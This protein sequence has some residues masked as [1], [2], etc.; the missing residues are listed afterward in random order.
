M[1]TRRITA[2]GGTVLALLLIAGCRQYE[3]DVSV[4]PDGSGTRTLRLQTDPEDLTE[5]ESDLEGF[6]GLYG[7]GPDSGWT[8]TREREEGS[9]QEILVFSRKSQPGGLEDWPHQSGDL[10]IRGTLEPGEFAGVAFTNEL[11]VE[12]VAGTNLRTYTYR[13]RFTW[14]GLREILTSRQAEGFY[15]R[16]HASYPYLTDEDRLEL[17]GLLAGAILATV[18]LE[19]S[20][21][22]REGVAE[23]LARAVEA[24]AE[25]ILH[26][27]DPGAACENLAQI[28][29][30]AIEGADQDLEAFLRHELPG[31]Y[32]A[33]ATSISLRVTMPGRIVDSNADR[34]EGRIATW[35]VDTWDALVR[36]VEVF[37]RSELSE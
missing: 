14:S 34:V 11:S 30:D 22:E 12:L 4:D 35:T 17:T 8:M 16:L 28:T 13:E 33:G 26:R 24:H 37:V 2:V 5:E 10:C 18:E 7:L 20:S 29:R 32:L 6:I 25:D 9:N 31:A 1:E 36:P 23:A 21:S 15:N 27:H 19:S 3:I